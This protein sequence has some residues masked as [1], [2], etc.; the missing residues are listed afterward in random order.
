M[1]REYVKGDTVYVDRWRDRVCG[2]MS[3]HTDTVYQIREM[4]V[5]MPLE[6]YVPKPVKWLTW[7]GVGAIVLLLLS[8]V[9]R[10]GRL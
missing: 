6:R 7:I 9:R 3:V 8:I 4:T 10:V 2:R 1:V 5:V